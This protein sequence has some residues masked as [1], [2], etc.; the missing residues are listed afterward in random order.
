MEEMHTS[1]TEAQVSVSQYNNPPF[2]Q[3]Y[4]VQMM[5]NEY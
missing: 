4:C 2:L 3:K 1:Y 5:I